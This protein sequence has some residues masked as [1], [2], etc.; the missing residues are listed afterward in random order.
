MAVVATV[1]GAAEAAEGKEAELDPDPDSSRRR[2]LRRHLPPPRMRPRGGPTS[3]GVR[4]HRHCPVV[5]NIINSEKMLTGVRSQELVPGRTF[6]Y[7]NQINEIRTS[8][9]K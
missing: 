4:T 3:R 2:R 7:L 6:G 1:E 5:K 9:R 8:L